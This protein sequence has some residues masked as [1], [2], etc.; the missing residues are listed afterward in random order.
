MESMKYNKSGAD[1]IFV[2]NQE[3]SNLLSG[4]Q[5]L[6]LHALVIHSNK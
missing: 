3:L 1:I 5:F 6:P 4:R 2:A